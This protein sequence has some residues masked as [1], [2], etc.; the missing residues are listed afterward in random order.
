MLTSLMLLLLKRLQ[1]PKPLRIFQ[2]RL[3]KSFNATLKT[4][5]LDDVVG[6]LIEPTFHS[7]GSGQA[8]GDVAV[9][10]KRRAVSVNNTLCSNFLRA[11]ARHL[12]RNRT[13]E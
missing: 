6:R 9:V 8:L 5:A 10:L 11:T 12:F 4:V 13:L 2:A 3:A 1:R 7:V